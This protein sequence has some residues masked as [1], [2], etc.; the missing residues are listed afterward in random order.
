MGLTFK[1]IQDEVKRRATRDQSGTDYNTPVKTLINT[2]LFR[3]GREGNWRVLRRKAQF[4]TVATYSTGSGAGS[5]DSTSSTITVTGATFLT[6]NIQPGRR[7]KLSGDGTTHVIK[8]ITG[9]TTLTIEENYGGTTTTTGTYSILGQ[10]EYNLPIQVGHRSFL[11]HREYGYPTKMEYITDQNFYESGVD[12]ISEAIPLGYRMWGN[13]MV[14]EQLKAAS[15]IRISSSAAA[16]VSIPVTV[17]GVVSG[18]PDYE[19]ITTNSSNGTTAVSGSKSF[20]SVERVAKGATSTGRITADANSAGTTV[21]VM[22]VGDTTAGIN[23][24]KIQLYP[25]PNSVF[26]MQ[27]QYYKDPYRLVN[28]GD[29]HELGQEFD[30]ALILLATAK[31]QYEQSKEDG[32]KFLGLYVD[33]VRNLK[34]TNIDKLDWFPS[35]NRP[36]MGSGRNM[37][38]NNLSYSQVGPYYGRRSY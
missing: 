16:D 9:E 14:K 8:T 17:F 10:E 3:L 2:S 33:E 18:Y 7:I 5:F 28:D 37:V 11:W 12:D 20:T 30:E 19:V 22:P 1:D 23:Y 15:V 25:L 36:N 31:L 38:H 26:E 34:K 29:V 21:A 35:L 24:S 6:D 27:V 4:N 13:D 32:D